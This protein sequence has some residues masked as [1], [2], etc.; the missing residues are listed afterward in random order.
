MHQ[1]VHQ[2]AATQEET[3]PDFGSMSDAELMAYVS[4][5]EQGDKYAIPFGFEPSGMSYQWKRAEVLGRPDYSN[6]AMMEQKG[7]KPVPQERH[8]GRWMPPG[9]KGATINDGLMLM[10]IPT[11]LLRA[12]E[13]WQQRQAS[14]QT[15][16]MTDRLS[17]TPPGS[18]PRDA[19][20]STKPQ[21][22][23]EHVQ[24]TFD[25]PP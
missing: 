14:G 16:S 23:R 20:P 21:I 11:P 10:E 7:W 24:V 3:T 8:D 25:V 12:K 15:D 1:P 18:A 22:R 2:P 19:H 5:Q 9:T 17:Y 6:L 4:R 13:V